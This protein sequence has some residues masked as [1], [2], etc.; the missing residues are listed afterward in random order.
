MKL[1]RSVH[2]SGF[3]SIRD[4]TLTELGSFTGL[5][6]KN[7]SGKSN[8]LRALNLFFNGEVEPRKPLVF[9]RDHFK[10]SHSKRKKQISITVDFNVPTQFK[11]RKE[12]AHLQTLGA[13]FSITRTW[14]L[15]QRRNVV[16]S[17][18]AQSGGSTVPNGSELAEQ[19]LGLVAYRYIPNRSIPSELLK[20]ESQAIADSI[21][22]R[23]K[24]DKHASALMGSL[25]AA[26]SRMLKAASDSMQASGSP[27]A[28]PSV[29]TAESIGEMLRMS[30]FQAQGQHGGT[31]QDEDWGAGHQAFFLYLVLHALDTNYGRFFGWRQATI[32]GVEEPE[33]ALHRDLETRL[34]DRLRRWALDQTSRLQIVHTTHSPVVTMAS[35]L[36]Y[37]VEL[38]KGA[39]TLRQ[40]PI[41]ELT[42]AAQIK[43]V[44]GWVHPVLSFPWNPVVLCEG[45][46]DVEV[47]SH[48]AAVAGLDHLRFLALPELD[49]SERSGGKDSVVAYVR[50]NQGLVQNRP[51]EAPLVVL[52]DWEISDQELKQARTA[53]GIGGDQR[54]LRMNAAHCDSLLGPDFRGIERFYPSAVALAAHQ[55]SELVLGIVS[56]KPYSVSA[57]QLKGGKASLLKRVRSIS[58]PK[59]L[60]SL[61]AVLADV[62]RIA[63][64]ST[65]VQILLPGIAKAA[66]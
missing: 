7:S 12:L 15:D 16:R 36:G 65:A 20:D 28:S 64:G 1:V 41:H 40:T 13:S 47:L 57:A 10:E 51:K 14:E 35:D 32:W 38:Q 34:A 2:I 54:V 53:Y 39:T 6:G 21:F 66:G 59:Q 8:V 61:V 62:D 24:G 60:Q 48:V 50:R 33:A 43:G 42:R 5:V 18:S 58:D 26:A 37:W 27:L 56:G 52:L 19:L 23:M 9:S 17:I 3:R 30:G 45:A 46:L 63:R 22:M 25:T 44:S 55:S 49:A 29:A 11:F 4:Q 31:V